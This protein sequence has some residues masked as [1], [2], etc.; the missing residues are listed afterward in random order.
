MSFAAKLQT[1][2]D[3]LIE[4]FDRYID[5]PLSGQILIDSASVTDAYDRFIGFRLVHAVVAVAAHLQS[6]RLPADD[7]AVKVS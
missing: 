1:V 5:Q 2:C 4:V 7:L 3:A 6:N